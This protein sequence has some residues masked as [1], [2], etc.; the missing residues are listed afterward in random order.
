MDSK[1]RQTSWAK[2]ACPEIPRTS[3]HMNRRYQAWPMPASS[4]EEEEQRPQSLLASQRRRK[5]NCA[6]IK[7]ITNKIF[8]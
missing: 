1:E 5:G 4:K 2:E 7:S 3:G 6:N 8:L